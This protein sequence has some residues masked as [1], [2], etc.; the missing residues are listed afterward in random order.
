MPDPT[1]A[2]GA[3]TD[4]DSDPLE[5]ILSRCTGADTLLT[6]VGG[7][8]RYRAGDPPAPTA[9]VAEMAAAARLAAQDAGVHAEE[10]AEAIR[11]EIP[12]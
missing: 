2:R 5:L 12:R 1:R 8:I 6:M 7:D 4:P 3:Y 10:I 11:Q 9:E